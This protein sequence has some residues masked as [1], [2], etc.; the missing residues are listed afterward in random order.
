MGWLVG[1]IRWIMFV[2][3][4]L[5]CTM[6]YAAIAPQAALKSH[7]G[8]SLEGPVADVV[9][10]NWGALIGLVGAML[11]YGA[12]APASRPLILT[13][14]SISKLVFIGLVIAN[15]LGAQAAMP[16]AV[17]LA[18]TLLF[19]AYLVTLRRGRALHEEGQS[20]RTI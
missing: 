10:R 9:V 3:G 8:E 12:F 2:S 18:V 20:V 5:T 17:D 11:I 6:L 7:F 1:S 14:A 19:I 4:A 15:G 16:I 13:V